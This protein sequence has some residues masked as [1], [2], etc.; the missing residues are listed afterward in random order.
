MTFKPGE[1]GNPKGRVAGVPNKRTQLIKL[2]EPHAPAL[3]NKCVELALEGN[4]ACLRLAIDKLLPRAKEQ[5]FEIKLPSEKIIPNTLPDIGEI[6]LRQLANGEITPE[7]ACSLLNV[8]KAY[9]NILP[10]E[11]SKPLTLIELFHLEEAKANR[12]S[13]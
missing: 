8:V 7:Q 11:Y 6:I 10:E 2:L 12:T 1:S 4:E 9:V 5:A 3:I 13:V